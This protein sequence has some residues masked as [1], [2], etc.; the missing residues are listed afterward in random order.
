VIRV[1]PRLPS[2]ITFLVGIKLILSLGAL[3]FARPIKA[4]IWKINVLQ[5]TLELFHDVWEFGIIVTFCWGQVL[6]VHHCRVLLQ[7]LFILPFF[8][9]LKSLFFKPSLVQTCVFDLVSNIDTIYSLVRNILGLVSLAW[10]IAHFAG[11]S[12]FI[13][14][15]SLTVGSWKIW[16]WFLIFQI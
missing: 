1:F 3:S 13:R 5:L 6:L 4:N 9:L 10:E 15:R 12:L 7:Q 8:F 11:L 14:R 2:W 16:S